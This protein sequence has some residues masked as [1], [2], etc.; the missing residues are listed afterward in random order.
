[1]R[2]MLSPTSA[3]MGKGLGKDVALI[4]DGRFS[5]GTHGFV[6]GRITSEAYIGG[7][8]AIVENGGTISIDAENNE[9]TLH[10]NEHEVAR[11][12]FY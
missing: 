4:T 1:M 11:S 6:I 10:V 7:A 3:V 5:C 9:V 12:G 8:L 2:E